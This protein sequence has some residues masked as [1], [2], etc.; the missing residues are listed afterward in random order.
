MHLLQI[1][2]RNVVCYL[3]DID[4]VRYTSQTIKQSLPNGAQIF[5]FG[6]S[7]EQLAAPGF[8]GWVF[9]VKN[10]IWSQSAT[11]YEEN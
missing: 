3:L 4:L 10:K 5:Y 11:V 1:Q 9:I 7:R 8:R 6:W 2:N